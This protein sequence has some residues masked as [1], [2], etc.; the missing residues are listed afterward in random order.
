MANRLSLVFTTSR[1]S[2]LK[3]KARYMLTAEPLHT[4]IFETVA[5]EKSH[6]GDPL[7]RSWILP[8]KHYLVERVSIAIVTPIMNHFDVSLRPCR[9][10]FGITRSPSCKGSPST[11]V[12][13]IG[14]Q[15]SSASRSYDHL[16]RHRLSTRKC[17]EI[18]N[19]GDT[20]CRWDQKRN[21]NGNDPL[22]LSVYVSH[23]S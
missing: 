6:F 10:G 4:L 11:R 14:D 5:R 2:G 13:S 23:V 7:D 16:E 15:T 1:H 19:N 8:S 17:G 22:H 9:L 12:S 21:G 18:G 3:Q 20:I